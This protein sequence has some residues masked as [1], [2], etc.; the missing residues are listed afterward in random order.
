MAFNEDQSRARVGHAA[1]NLAIVRR[2]ALNLLRQSKGSKLGVKNKRL[3][4]AYDD[5]FRASV[6]QLPAHEQ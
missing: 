6:L 2:F 5:A 3:R 4:A 1:E